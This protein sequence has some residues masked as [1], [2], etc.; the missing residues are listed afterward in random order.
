MRVIKMAA[1]KRVILHVLLHVSF[2]S[3]IC[4]WS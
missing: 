1:L 2:I 3:Q 4:N